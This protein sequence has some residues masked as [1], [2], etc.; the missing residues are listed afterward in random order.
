MKKKKT[1]FAAALLACTLGLSGCGIFGPSYA[2][3]MDAISY[4]AKKNDVLRQLRSMK[5]SL[6]GT[7]F[8]KDKEGKVIET[9]VYRH[10][11]YEGSNLLITYTYL[12]FQDGLLV[13]KKIM[14]D[15]TPQGYKPEVPTPE[16]QTT[17]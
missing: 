1:F 5:S 12:I 10:T 9:L 16:V 3:K 11:Q 17:K 15:T 14:S 2:S 7:E 13:E 4:G 6:Q 8:Y